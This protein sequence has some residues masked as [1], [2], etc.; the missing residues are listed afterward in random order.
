M[1]EK[2]HSP[3]SVFQRFMTRMMIRF[4]TVRKVPVDIKDINEI[5]SPQLPASFEL[6]IPGGVGELSILD[7]DLALEKNSD[8]VSAE[9]LC[10]FSVKVKTST[11]YNNHL[12]LTLQA[13]P[14][15]SA[16]NKTISL[17]DIK[18]NSMELVSDEYSVIKDTRTLITGFLPE[19]LKSIF[20]STLSASSGLLESIGISEMVKYLSLYLTGSKQRIIEY[21]HTE[22]ENKI[23]KFAKSESF[24]YRLDEAV[25]EEQLF[26]DFGKQVVIENGQ[27]IFVFHS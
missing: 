11:I 17:A 25:F 1:I 23:I 18:I 14:D 15:Y 19:P 13:K 22:I 4:K 6:T 12:K 7:V 16:Q 8:S 26:A 20:A 24:S 27:L 2:P 3:P 9:L 5:I 10:N 21:H